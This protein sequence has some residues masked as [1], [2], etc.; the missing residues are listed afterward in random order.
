MA[1]G[2]NDTAAAQFANGLAKLSRHRT[3]QNAGRT[4]KYL[5]TIE[6]Y[7]MAADRL[8]EFSTKGWIEPCR[9]AQSV[10]SMVKGD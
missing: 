8:C 5:L 4:S 2:S 10:W 9:S 1:W 6:F 7:K 3:K